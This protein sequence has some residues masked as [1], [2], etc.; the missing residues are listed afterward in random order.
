[1]RQAREIKK[2]IWKSVVNK[3]CRLIYIGLYYNQDKLFT[4]K[5]YTNRAV[6]K[7]EVIVASHGS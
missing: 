2:F 5:S 7:T 6:G 1:M 4:I 3:L